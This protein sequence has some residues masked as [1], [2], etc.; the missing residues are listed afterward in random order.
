MSEGDLYPSSAIAADN[1]SYCNLWG[2]NISETYQ[3]TWGTWKFEGKT[4]YDPSPV[5]YCV[6][7]ARYLMTFARS[8]W[9]IPANNWANG[10]DNVEPGSAT[11]PIK[12]HYNK[13]GV[14]EM[15]F[16]ANGL[17]STTA[18]D[19][20][21]ARGY[22]RSPDAL[23][24]YHTSTPYSRDENFQLHLYF[25]DSPAVDTHTKILGD[26]C[27][28][29]SVLPVVW[30]G[31]VAGSDV[32][33]EEQ[34]LT[35]T[36]PSAGALYW[37]KDDLYSTDRK[38]EYS[39]DN[40]T[41]WTEITPESTHLS[42][43][44]NKITI[45]N[46]GGTVLVRNTTSSPNTTYCRQ[47]TSSGRDYCYFYSADIH[48]VSG[49]VMSLFYA[50]D[51]ADKTAFPSGSTYSLSHLFY[52]DTNLED[53]GE[54][55]L[56][57]TTLTTNCYESMFQ[58]CTNLYATP[59]L[60]ATS[61]VSNCYENMFRGCTNLK[62]VNVMLNPNNSTAYTEN[63]LNGVASTGTFTCKNGATWPSGASGIPSGWTA[64]PVE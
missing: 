17:R 50:T 24:C 13:S 22:E 2:T 19:G 64:V 56:P 27:E 6:P 43:G 1:K 29:L 55:V 8:S 7:P 38:I 14:G 37:M 31:A 26:H 21:M 10:F 62:S 5:G 15:Y 34:Y 39:L 42:N 28:A 57:A 59:A 25:Y 45:T 48:E 18:G 63:W 51:F 12:C 58:G 35:F 30:T 49:N 46:A 20:M 3:S 9:L 44:T 40:G 36:F 33:P 16:C 11:F 32:E 23:A 60:P 47:T 54:L 41:T 53:V 52:N 61:P 4:I